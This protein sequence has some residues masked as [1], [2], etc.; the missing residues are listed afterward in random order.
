MWHFVQPMLGASPKL[1]CLSGFG[2]HTDTS[3]IPQ[4]SLTL[5]NSLN[6]FIYPNWA[7]IEKSIR[8]R[9][10]PHLTLTFKR[11]NC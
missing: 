6:I 4:H 7:K 2:L 9:N 10:P 5:V 3:N 8:L 11:L 1:L